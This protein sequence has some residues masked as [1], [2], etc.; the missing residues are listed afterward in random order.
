M[1]LTRADLQG[2]RALQTARGRRQQRAFL[3]EGEKLVRE[4][5][6]AGAPI[7]RLLATP[8]A[9]P[10]L[11]P[12][13]HDITVEAISPAQA[14]RLADTR[15]PQGW[16]A[17]LEDRL[18]A[19]PDLLADSPGLMLALDGVQDPGNVGALIRVAAALGAGALLVGEGSADPTQPKVLR[20]ATGAWFRVALVRAAPLADTL[21]ATAAAGY[22]CWALDRTGASLYTPTLWPDRLVLVLGSEGAGLSPAVAAVAERRIAIPMAPGVES[23]NVAVAAGIALAECGRATAR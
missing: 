13:S 15:T 22:R 4:A 14:E 2:L 11:Q 5:L 21:R 18:P 19:L 17:V 1:S 3:I 9:A 6:T 8:D 23:L 10:L 16:F 20:A 12:L 7:R